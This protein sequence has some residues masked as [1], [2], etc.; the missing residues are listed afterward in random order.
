M[1]ANVTWQEVIIPNDGI[2]IVIAL[3]V[4][5][6]LRRSHLLVVAG[7]VNLVQLLHAVTSLPARFQSQCILS[8]EYHSGVL[9][10]RIHSTVERFHF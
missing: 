7:R 8:A 9:T 3:D 2:I 4:C 10:N 1:N 6:S 5:C